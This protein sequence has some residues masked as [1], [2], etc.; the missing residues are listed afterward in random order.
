MVRADPDREGKVQRG[1]IKN[2]LSKVQ[3]VGTVKDVVSWEEPGYG[4]QKVGYNS[5]PC[6]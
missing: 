1:R 5:G 3:M 2:K 4:V 6:V